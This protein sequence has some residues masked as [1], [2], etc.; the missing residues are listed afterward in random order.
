MEA[1][2]QDILIFA[3]MDMAI[4]QYSLY[5]YRQILAEGSKR[6][7]TIMRYINRAVGVCTVT[8][9][10]VGIYLEDVGPGRVGTRL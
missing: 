4:L 3:P 8:V 7:R 2:P 9:K 10:G 1:I 6:M 5:R